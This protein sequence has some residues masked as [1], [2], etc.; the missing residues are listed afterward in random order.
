M[1][2][3]G[4]ARRYGEVLSGLPRSDPAPLVDFVPVGYDLDL[5][6]V[7]LLELYDIVNLF[8]LYEAPFTHKVGVRAPRPSQCDHSQR[9]CFHQCTRLWSFDFPLVAC[10]SAHT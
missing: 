1:T 4:R 3:L 7:R 9:Q 2:M 10:L 6:E 8:V 5:L